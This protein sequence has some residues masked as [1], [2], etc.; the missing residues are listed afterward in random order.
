VSNFDDEDLGGITV[1]KGTW[2]SSNTMYA[3]IMQQVGP[4]AVVDEATKLGVTAPMKPVN[5]AVLGTSELSVLDLTSAYSTLARRGSSIAPYVI[6]R[7][8]ASD[9]SV[10]YDAG[11]PKGNQV[12]SEAVADTVTTVLRGGPSRWVDVR[13]PSGILQPTIYGYGGTN[14]YLVRS[15]DGAMFFHEAQGRSASLPVAR[16]QG[17]LV[18]P[19][20]LDAPQRADLTP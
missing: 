14:R 19:S 12:V 9:G 4:Q 8:E 13:T 11:E 5:S 1:E 16:E 7:V 10:L 18:F 6:R 17:F 3:Q 2:L 15:G 20:D